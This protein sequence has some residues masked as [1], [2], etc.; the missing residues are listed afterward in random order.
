MTSPTPTRC[1]R[2]VGVFLALFAWCVA[3]E[4]AAGELQVMFPTASS[5]LP[6]IRSGKVRLLAVTSAEPSALAPN[7]PPIAGNA[8]FLSSNRRARKVE[9]SGATS[10]P[11][12]PDATLLP[13]GP[14]I[15]SGLGRGELGCPFVHVGGKLGSAASALPLCRTGQLSGDAGVRPE[16][17]AGEMTSPLGGI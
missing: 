8:P 14:T 13:D 9:K 3:G 2:T 6:H 4:D 12:G 7:V 15:G 10:L 5:A 16:R 17:T 11:A 1:E